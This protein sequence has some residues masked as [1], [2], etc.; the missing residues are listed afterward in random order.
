M[1]ECA[2]THCPKFNEILQD[3]GCNKQTVHQRVG[4]EEDKKLIVG[5]AHTVVHP[6][7]LKKQQHYIIREMV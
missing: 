7:E 4:Q 5:K 6:R 1:F 2:H 3:C